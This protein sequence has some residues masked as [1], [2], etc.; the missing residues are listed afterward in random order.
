MP[1][2]PKRRPGVL[3]FVLFAGVVIAYGYGVWKSPVWVIGATVA[4]LGAGFALRA[5]VKRHLA[6]LASSR[7]Q[8]SICTFARAFDTRS[9][10]PWVIRAVYEELQDHLKAEYPGFPI[11]PAD[12]LREDLKLD[13]DDLEMDLAPDIAARTGR[14]L[15]DSKDNPY[16]GKVTT[17]QDFVEFF[18]AQPKVAT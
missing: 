10:D 17:V 4:L 16:R 2:A 11:L 18:C 8:E 5:Q 6:R 15:V 14:S 7:T 13:D 3:G 12:R 9:V 1:K